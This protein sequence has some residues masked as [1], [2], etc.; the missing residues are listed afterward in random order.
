MRD[1][2]GERERYIWRERIFRHG[3]RERERERERDV[4]GERER[5]L[6]RERERLDI[7]R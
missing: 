1:V 3:K 6:F 4:Q 2:Q 5:Y 7:Y